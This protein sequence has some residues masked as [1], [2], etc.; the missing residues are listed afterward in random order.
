[1]KQSLTIDP[2]VTE[3]QW[4]L[5]YSKKQGINLEIENYNIIRK[6][7]S[8]I[9]HARLLKTMRYML[10]LGKSTKKFFRKC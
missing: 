2:E 6:M 9:S 7:L 8:C 5:N 4:A 10:T 1:M 3:I